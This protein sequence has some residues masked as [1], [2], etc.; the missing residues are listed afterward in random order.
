[1]TDLE[2]RKILGQYNVVYV[3][4]VRQVCGNSWKDIKLKVFNSQSRNVFIFC[5]KYEEY[6]RHRLNI[7]R[8]ESTLG[9]LASAVYLINFNTLNTGG[10][11]GGS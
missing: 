2:Y 9:A 1:M 3:P 6:F 5:Q 8:T 11:R 7:G 4:V 10:H